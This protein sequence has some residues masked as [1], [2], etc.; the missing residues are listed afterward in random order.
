MRL[1]LR[2]LALHPL[3]ARK[4]ACDLLHATEAIALR[5]AVRARGLH[6][7]DASGFVVRAGRGPR[8]AAGDGADDLLWC[9]VNEKTGGGS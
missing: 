7:V 6:R 4:L 1:A 2:T 3:A 5:V 9:R 8:L